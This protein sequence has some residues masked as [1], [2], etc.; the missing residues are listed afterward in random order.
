MRVIIHEAFGRLQKPIIWGMNE[1]SID[2]HALLMGGGRV[3]GPDG[4]GARLWIPPMPSGY[5][6]AQLDDHRT[7]PRG[8]FPWRPPVTLRVRARTSAATPL[9]TLGF[10]F[11][12]DPFSLTFGQAGAARKLPVPPRAV[13]FF[14]GS[15]PSDM[16]L[17]PPNP[18]WGWKAQIID[19]PS[20]PGWLL[21]GPAA[22]AYAIAKLPILRRPL[23]RT[24]LRFIA[25]DERVLEAGLDTWHT[26]EIRWGQDGVTFAVDGVSQLESSMSPDGPLGFVTWIDNQ[27]AIASP[28]GGLKFGV[29]ATQTEQSLELTHLKLG[30]DADQAGSNRD[31]NV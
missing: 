27:Y 30:R 7:L 5:A 29:L 17:A 22:V 4:G 13:W 21:A 12:N 18:G 2:L 15:P 23:M 28:T 1:A 14:Y 6:N 9:G 10:G 3:D 31:A 24:T 8:N 26:Y 19:A 20:V 11:W 16:L 25:C